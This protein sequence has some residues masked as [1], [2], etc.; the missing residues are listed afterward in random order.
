MKTI[1]IAGGSGL[2]GT[3]LATQLRKN[4]HKVHILTRRAKSKGQIYWNPENNTIEGKH[5]QTIEIIINLAGENIGEKKWTAERK[6]E[7]T[8]SRLISTQFLFKSAK[9]MPKLE[10]Y[11]GMSGVNCYAL[12]G[13]VHRE[14]DDFGNYFL[15]HLVEEWEA[16]HHA[17][18]SLCKVAI[19]RCGT[20]LTKKGGALEKMK[21][22]IR[23]W[24]GSPLGNGNQ[25]LSWIHKED[26]CKMF[27]FLLNQRASG[28]FNAVGNHNSNREFLS[29]LAK[30][31]NKPFFFPAVPEWVLKS[32]LGEMSSLVLDD[33]RADNSKIKATG[34]EFQFENIE[35]ALEDLV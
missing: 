5:L 19:L 21:T 34:F 7:L 1:L 28:V 18:N 16:A 33:L 27:E 11:I 10:Y 30:K 12:D 3:K 22:P 6:K 15:A 31:M 29:I 8:N 26:L 4:G 24:I 20:V 32:V 23:F 2:I 17:F 14:T 35:K 25:H 9:N 13:T